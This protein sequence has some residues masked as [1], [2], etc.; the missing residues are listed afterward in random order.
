MFVETVYTIIICALVQF[1]IQKP[2]RW[3]QWLIVPLRRWVPAAASF[4]EPYLDCPVPENP[5]PQTMFPSIGSPR[6]M[7]CTSGMD[8]ECLSRPCGSSCGPKKSKTKSFET[9]V[10]DY[11]AETGTKVIIIHHGETSGMV[12]FFNKQE[13]LGERDARQFVEIMRTIEPT[14]PIALI[15][16]TNGGAMT[17]AEV[18]VHALLNHQAP[19][20]VYIPYTCMS[21]GTL[22][23]LTANEIIMDPNAYCGT[24]DPQMFGLSVTSILGFCQNYSESTSIL[25]DLA[26]LVRTQAQAAMDRV[27]SILDQMP[28]I[29]ER[30]DLIVSELVSGRH[31]HDK[32]FFAKHMS[33]LV[34][35][36]V[37]I[38]SD[39]IGLYRA[40]VSSRKT[41]SSNPFGL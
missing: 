28:Q 6:I 40:F 25:G 10:A 21:A 2:S 29:Q 12:S 9:M 26:R 36:R 1:A 39:V 35:I 37:G 7:P 30:Q 18:I 22:I 11:E 33:A 34:P 15:L 14:T 3:L 4:L 41:P 13:S 5:F 19:I 20:T 23:A 27:R 8:D 24:I 17:S 38:P 31:N 16:N 32:P